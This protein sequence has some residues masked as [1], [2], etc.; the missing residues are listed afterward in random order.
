MAN[1]RPEY[2]ADRSLILQL[3]LGYFTSPDA[4]A[5]L[6]KVYDRSFAPLATEYEEAIA[7]HRTLQSEVNTEHQ[8]S[9]TSDGL[10]DETQRLITL[11]V[12]AR[13]GKAGLK[14]L[15]RLCGGRTRSEVTRLNIGE[16]LTVVGEMIVRYEAGSTITID[17]AL[18]ATQKAQLAD[19]QLHWAAYQRALGG[20][21]AA[22]VRLDAA[23]IAFDAG[24]TR[25]VASAKA[26]LSE[27]ELAR[28]V[29]DFTVMRAR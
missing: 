19:G 18:L 22:R 10:I 1:Y 7:A 9:V 16:E 24:W 29:P 4:D 13:H 23:R 5:Q 26:L 14:E 15:E 8:N 20:Q 25:F 11:D 12:E 17:P 27:A 2:D 3:A 6:K 21:R 28:I